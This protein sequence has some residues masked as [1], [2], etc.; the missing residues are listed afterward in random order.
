LRWKEL[1]AGLTVGAFLGCAYTN[2]I[3]WSIGA[4][5]QEWI[6]KYHSSIWSYLK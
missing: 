2:F 5:F 4:K 1:N 3:G 6:K